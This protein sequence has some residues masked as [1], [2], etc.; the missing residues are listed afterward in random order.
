VGAPELLAFLSERLAGF[1]RPRTIEFV[2]ELPRN[3]AGKV[4]KSELRAP[5]WAGSGRAI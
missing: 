4:L 5:Y 2:Q 3:A 1:K